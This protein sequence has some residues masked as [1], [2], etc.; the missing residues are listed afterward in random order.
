M[1][2]KARIDAPGA[3]HHI[4]VRG[5]NRRKIFF[6]DLDRDDFLD[7]LGGILSDS[8]T[9]C[10][11]WAFMGNHLHLLLKTGA[12]PIAT[13][14][15][16]LLTGYAVSFNRRH[17]R[18]GHLFQN[19]YKSI[20]CQEDPY[21]LE[22][23]RYIHLNP[24]RAGIVEE[25]KVLDS[26]PYCGHGA[27]MGKTEH[28]FQDVDYILNRFGGKIAQARRLYLEFVKKGVAA[29]RRPDLTGGGLVRSVG[30]WSVLRTM[31]KNESRMKGD[32][33][34]LGQGDFVK[35][36]LK[37][38]LENLDRK[39][40]I[41]AQGYD[42]EWLVD[43]VTGLFG[44]TI[45]ELLTGGKQRRTVKAWSVLCYWGTRE[46]G[47]SAVG[48]SKKLNIAPSTASESVIRGRQIVEKQ[49]LKLL[50]EHFE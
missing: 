49:G 2:R 28:G 12:A 45:K 42:F 10:F 4:I 19:R 22:L 15:R 24:L 20:L 33:R 43:R 16:R 18:H 38:A 41:Q 47:M 1:P 26:Y 8:K 29:G 44:L 30:G 40:M 13:V 3:L 46:L 21:L 27:L 14:M 34:I 17:R 48:I 36:V 50:D 37:A 31:R 11:A 9:P 5:I 25:L 39:S 6:D 35:T 23:V 32:E 7:R